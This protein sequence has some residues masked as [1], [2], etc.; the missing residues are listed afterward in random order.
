MAFPTKPLILYGG[1]LGPNPAKVAI[2]LEE[3]EVPWEAVYIPYSEIKDESYT[4]INPNGRL[5]ALID[6]NTGITVWESGAIIEYAISEY[7]LTHKIS[8]PV[9]S[10]EDYHTKQW[11]FFQVSGQG[12]YP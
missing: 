9:N 6:P 2:V 3:L 5:P 1:A 10:A 12:M 11:L 8:F 4:K 7:D